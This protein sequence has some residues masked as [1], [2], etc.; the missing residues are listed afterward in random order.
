MNEHT[1]VIGK[2]LRVF[3]PMF[4]V[5]LLIVAILPWIMPT[6]NIGGFLLSIFGVTHFLPVNHQNIGDALYNFNLTTRILGIMGSF[7]S[8]LPLLISTLVMIKLC[9]NYSHNNVFS[10][11]NANAYSRL[12]ILYLLSAIILQ[13]LSQMFFSFGIS[14]SNKIGP[15]F[16]ATG[17][18]ISNLTAI[19]F[20]VILIIIGQVMKAAHKIAEEQA[21]TV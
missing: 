12:G 10:V 4:F 5:L 13:P 20:S 18:D 8:L 2:A 16:I 19:F 17:F 7:I 21:L 9:N 15:H 1:I 6:S 14:L 11:A 3:L